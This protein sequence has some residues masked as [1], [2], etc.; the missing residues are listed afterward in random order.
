[1]TLLA[2]WATAIAGIVGGG[3]LLLFYLLKLRRR[4]VRVSS[5]LYWR[6]MARDQEANVPLRM[7]R[8]TLLLLLQALIVALLAIA[9]GRPA[10]GGGFGGASGVVIIVDQSASMAAPGGLGAGE[11]ETALDEAK[12]EARRIADEVMRAGASAMIVALGAEAR[13]LTAM[14]SDRAA[15]RRAVDAINQ[16]DQPAVL[17]E[18]E[19]LLSAM[20]DVGAEE[21]APSLAVAIM[22]DGQRAPGERPLM[23]PGV[24]VRERR[25]GVAQPPAN[26]GIIGV[27]ARRDYRDPAQ[28]RVFVRL[29]ASPT[30]PER[31]VI[32]LLI[33][34]ETLDRRTVAIDP[35]R[36]AVTT[37]ELRSTG[38]ATVAVAIEGDDAIEADN[39]AAVRLRPAP[40]ARAML[41][42]PEGE[43]IDD[44]RRS[45]VW[46]IADVLQA[47]D[48]RGVDIVR[49]SRYEQLARDGQLGAWDAVVFD[50]VSP[51]GP[52]PL[53]SL[54]FGAAIPGAGWVFD[55][56][57]PASRVLSWRREHPALRDISLD[58]VQIGAGALRRAEGADAAGA[59]EDLAIGRAGPLIVLVEQAGRRRIIV[60]F[61]PAASS[62][63][64]QVGFPVFVADA[65]DFITL[66]GEA[67]AG[68]MFTTAEPV[69]LRLAGEGG[70]AGGAERA[71]GGSRARAAPV[72]RGPAEITGRIVPDSA[73]LLADFGLVERAG[74][75]RLADAVPRDESI[76][77]VNLS[78]EAET[79]L[80]RAEP[81]EE[82]R[83]PQ[84]GEAVAATGARE[85]WHWFAL[86]ALA[87]SLVEWVVSVWGSRW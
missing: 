16:T 17:A 42:V 48:L 6:P 31:A 86:A 25:V 39:G 49:A 26:A 24:I 52:P 74:V 64:R 76:A 62:W 68:R 36:G 10:I 21:E 63:P 47:M 46:L 71:G 77:A 19:R 59:G 8:P 30:G 2:P 54:S 70:D 58:T 22:T 1:V 78:N 18:A 85:I 51:Q 32:S 83:R 80:A 50:R 60:G 44:A 53:P 57:A 20:T 28:V 41:V 12:R 55:A 38:A 66:R 27:A 5:I 4:P 40:G 14:T 79:R 84:A 67:E 9:L 72:L 75:Y 65:L 45:P 35:L 37:F 56:E 82:F 34:G 81:L 3:A 33:D 43:L 13:P 73:G 23:A 29:A 61:E 15:L 87:L 7:L 11:G 69:R